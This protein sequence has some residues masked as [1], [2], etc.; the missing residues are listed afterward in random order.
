MQTV[1]GHVYDIDQL[2]NPSGIHPATGMRVAE[3]LVVD[4]LAE[5]RG[6]K[7][8]AQNDPGMPVGVTSFQ[9]QPDQVPPGVIAAL[10]LHYGVTGISVDLAIQ[11]PDGS[12]HY[13]TFELD[14][15]QVAEVGQTVAAGTDVAAA[16]FLAAKPAALARAAE[17]WGRGISLV[18]APEG[19]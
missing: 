1:N 13:E 2:L 14:A 7:P 11:K 19:V 10:D 17:L 16:A 8:T 6:A 4:L 5:I 9:F 12:P 15:D 18:A 3:S